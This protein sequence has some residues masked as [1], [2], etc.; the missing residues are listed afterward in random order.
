MRWWRWRGR[1]NDILFMHVTCKVSLY[2]I[3]SPDFAAQNRNEVQV[4][5]V[6]YAFIYI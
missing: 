3:N 4:F 1:W 6:S 5:M 2:K